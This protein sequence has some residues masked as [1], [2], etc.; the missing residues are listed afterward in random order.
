MLVRVAQLEFA[1]QGTS[2]NSCFSGFA[3][4]PARKER[5]CPSSTCANLM[6]E[7]LIP[8]ATMGQLGCVVSEGRSALRRSSELNESTLIGHCRKRMTCPVN[9]CG[10]PVV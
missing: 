4:D 1:N 3:S 10:G 7:I 2:K 6:R 8:E 9:C 5:G